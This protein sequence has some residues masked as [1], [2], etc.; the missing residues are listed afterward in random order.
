MAALKIFCDD[1]GSDGGEFCVVGGYLFDDDAA[2]R[3]S[4]AWQKV[5][6]EAPA[7]K[8]FK[9]KEAESRRGEFW[10]FTEPDRDEK[11]MSLAE[12]VKA[13]ALYGLGSFISHKAYDSI[14]RGYLPP[15]VDHPYWFC[16]Q[17]IIGGVLHLYENELPLEKTDFVFDSQGVGY[18]RRGTLMHDGWKQMMLEVGDAL[19]GSITFADDKQVLPLQAADLLAWHIRRHANVMVGS[20]QPESRP[21][22]DLLWSVDTITKAWHPDE[23]E[24]FID[25]Y[26]TLHP[27]S[28]RN[29]DLNNPPA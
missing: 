25:S 11:V 19:I 29:L 21:V 26:H 22:A 4:E 15:T 3:F 17:G 18:E 14:A 9:M 2:M 16:F 8:Y 6:K 20:G 27:Q 28:P 10:G 13:H 12:V 7:I 23:I 1:S 24:T 5:L